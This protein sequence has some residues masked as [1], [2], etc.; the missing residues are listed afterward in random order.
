V[1]VA[2][3]LNASE[4]SAVGSESYLRFPDGSGLGDLFLQ[5]SNQFSILGATIL[6]AV[7]VSDGSVLTL[8]RPGR[9]QSIA[10]RGRAILRSTQTNALSLFVTNE[11]LIESNSWVDASAMD[12]QAA[13]PASQGVVLVVAGIRPRI[14]VVGPVTEGWVAPEPT[15]AI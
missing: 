9:A 7:T 11:V 6:R 8:N 10:L 5:S 12:S 1:D 2:S 13:A 3:V 14:T 4:A 15:R